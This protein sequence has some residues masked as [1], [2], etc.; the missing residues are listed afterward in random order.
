MCHVRTQKEESVRQHNSWR[1][2]KHG[3]FKEVKNFGTAKDEDRIAILYSEAC[4]WLHTHSGQRLLDFDNEKGKEV[5]EAARVIDHID[6]VL[7]NGTQLLLE[8]V[9]DSIGFKPH[10]GRDS[11]PSRH[12]TCLHCL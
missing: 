12:C 8:R 6:S 5:E 2:K 4:H 11:T 10:P 1:I 3:T 9:Y 7:I